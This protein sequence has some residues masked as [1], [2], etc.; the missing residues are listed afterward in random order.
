[1]FIKPKL[2][3]LHLA[4]SLLAPSLFIV[5]GQSLSYARKVLS[6]EVCMAW[7]LL[8]VTAPLCLGDCFY[9]TTLCRIV[10]GRERKIRASA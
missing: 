5:T 4:G 1:M 2:L 3:F 8:Q 10:G 9:A 6:P 7:E